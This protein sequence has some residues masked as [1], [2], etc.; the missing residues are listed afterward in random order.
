MKNDEDLHM[1]NVRIYDNG[2]KTFDRYTVLFTNRPYYSKTSTKAYDPMR[3]ALAMSTYPFHPQGYG[4]HCSAVPGRH[5]G[6]RI[7]FKDLPPDCQTLVKQNLDALPIPQ[8]LK[9]DVP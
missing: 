3:E 8:T 9:R 5:L 4:Q 1:S 2:G 6:K 7:A